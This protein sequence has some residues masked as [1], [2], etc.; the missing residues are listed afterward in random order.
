M[1]PVAPGGTI[2][3]AGKTVSRIGFGT[4]RLAGHDSWGNLR[5]KR[6]EPM[7]VLLEAIRLHGITHIDTADAYGPHTVENLIHDTL[8]PY[9]FDM[10]VLIATKVGMLRP[11]P[12]T[13]TPH[14]YPAYLRAAVEGS[15]RRLGVEQLDLCYL[16]RNDPAVP[17]LD[18]VGALAELQAEGK[19]AHIGLS[20]VGPEEIDQAATVAPIAAVQNKLNRERPDD[21]ATVE[22]CRVLGIPYVAYSPL[23]SGALAR[24]GGA[25]DAL[26][27]LLGL[28]PHVA[29]MPG[30]SDSH[31]LGE[32]VSALAD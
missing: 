13:W 29:P 17:F 7:A 32:L 10:D 3:I 21:L 2:T 24:D 28:S 1:S 23:G 27:W 16:H 12:R 20:K 31:H 11:G 30:T 8:A 25:G 14:G 15:L 9:W 6:V 26:E 22:H 5:T 4:M 18:Q 19:I